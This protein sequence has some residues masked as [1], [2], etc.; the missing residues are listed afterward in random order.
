MEPDFRAGGLWAE[1]GLG[2]KLPVS[3]EHKSGQIHTEQKPSSHPWHSKQATVGSFPCSGPLL[4]VF[5]SYVAKPRSRG[6][7]MSHRNEMCVVTCF[8]K[9]CPHAGAQMLSLKDSSRNTGET[10]CDCKIK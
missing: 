6:A 10:V 4:S 2:N 3:V 8:L 5:P 9:L 7:Q 1:P